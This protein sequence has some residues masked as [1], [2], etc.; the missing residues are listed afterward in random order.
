M[1]GHR[2][3]SGAWVGCWELIQLNCHCSTH[4]ARRP[5]LKSC[6]SVPSEYV[7]KLLVGRLEFFLSCTKIKFEID[8]QTT[9]LKKKM[10][11]IMTML[12]VLLF[13]SYLHSKTFGSRSEFFKRLPR[14]NFT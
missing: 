10:E 2:Q 12:H 4:S 3:T 1:M 11:K 7:F 9:E 14:S 13:K 5:L 6:I 8:P